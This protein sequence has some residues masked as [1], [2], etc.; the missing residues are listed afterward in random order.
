M[1]APLAGHRVLDLTQV[2]A[3]PY[4]SYLLGLLGAE[5][6]KIEPPEGDWSRLGG[7]DR[8]LAAAGLGT[9]FLTQNAGK[10]SLALDLKSA[11]G[12]QVMRR[13]IESADV[14]VENMRPG[15]AG[16]L[17]IGWEEART[18]NP[19][20]VYCSIS[21]FGQDGPLGPR[22]AYDHI[23]QGMCGIMTLTG[24]PETAPNKV[25]SPYVDYATGLNGAFAALAGVM[26]RNRTGEGQHVDVAMLDTSLL[27]MSSLIVNYLAT[28]TAPAPAGNEAFSG[29]PS[30]G[31][32]PTT[33]GLLLLAA[34]NERQ[35]RR[36]CTAIGRE[37][38]PGDPR[39][40]EPDARKENAAAL[41]AEFAAIF[42]RRSAVEW[43]DELNRAG[44]PAVRVRTL[45]EVLTEG[46]VDARGLFR[47]AAVAGTDR[48]VRV[49]T[50][51]FKAGGEVAAARG[52]A[53]ALGQDTEELLRELGYEA[54]EIASLSRAGV[55]GG[56]AT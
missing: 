37:D 23:V 13:L 25:G 4:C 51:G 28:G 19:K 44:V 14:L 24:T 36:L 38:I 55:V 18:W 11:E 42:A 54:G 53:P 12:R 1:F 3:G 33:A 49:P 5:V 41:R 20:L 8:S 46:Q 32:Y 31:S 6:V 7:G 35:F 9:A 16:R 48:E 29:S 45:P 52:A 30:S 2:L 22:P 10:R 47:P 17:G 43:E 40:A 26:E 21:A 34:N 56:A 15:T 27:L 50:L 39:W